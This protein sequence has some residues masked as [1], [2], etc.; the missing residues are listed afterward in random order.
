MENFIENRML[1]NK[2]FHTVFFYNYLLFLKDKF[3]FFIMKM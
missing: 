1:L 2:T 3:V